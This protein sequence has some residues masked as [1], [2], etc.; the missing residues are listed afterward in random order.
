MVHI[1]MYD[2]YALTGGAADLAPHTSHKVAPAGVSAEATVA[3]AAARLLTELFPRQG[4]FVTVKLTE[5]T[6]DLASTGQT[7]A[8]IAAGISFGAVI[9]ADVI[10]SRAADLSIVSAQ[11]GADMAYVFAPGHHQPD[12]FATPQGRHAAR[13]G[14]LR[15]FCIPSSTYDHTNFLDAPPNWTGSADYLKDF[16]EVKKEG[17]FQTPSRSPKEMVIATFWAYDGAW[18]IGTPPRLYNQCLQAVVKALNDSGTLLTT[19]QLARLFALTNAGM[20]DAGIIAWQAK[21]FY[22]LWRP[23]IGIRQQDEGYGSAHGSGKALPHGDPFW[24]PLGLPATNQ[25]GRLSTTPNFPAYPSGHASFGTTCF[26]LVR[27]FLDEEG[28]D[29][30]L[31]FNVMSDELNGLHH[32]SD[33]SVR[34]PHLR[35]LTLTSAIDENIRSRIYLGVHWRFDGEGDGPNHGYGGK[36]IGTILAPAVIAGCFKKI[37]TPLP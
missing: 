18:S 12:P 35:T 30:G 13:W 26:E 36:A 16:K 22:D 33:G 32:D 31:E 19:A 28:I 23:V 17:A 29:S 14:E 7:P 11:D 2:A 37:A 1:G 24:R 6:A 5:Y 8:A 9:A 21:Y 34:T 20:A 27:L 15:S 3:G 10:A 4:G 25:L